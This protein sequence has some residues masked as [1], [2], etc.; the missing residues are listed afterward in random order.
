MFSFPSFGFKLFV[1]SVLLVSNL[2][3]FSVSSFSESGTEIFS[4]IEFRID[5]FQAVVCGTVFS[6]IPAGLP[7]PGALSLGYSFALFI[8]AEEAQYNLARN[9]RLKKLRDW[10]VG[11]EKNWNRGILLCDS[12]SV[13]KMITRS[14]TSTNQS[15]SAMN[16]PG[17]AAQSGSE[18]NRSGSLKTD[19]FFKTCLL[20]DISEPIRNLR[21][22]ARLFISGILCKEAWSFAF[23]PLFFFLLHKARVVIKARVLLY[24]NSTLFTFSL[25]KHL[26]M[27]NGRTSL[28]VHTEICSGVQESRLTDFTRDMCTPRLRWMPAQRIQRK[29]PRFHDAQRGP[30]KK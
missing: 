4:W 24:I 28:H 23:R 8:F 7:G 26:D 3:V 5:V 29:T 19:Q 9:V 12:G 1:V 10:C 16:R 30:E 2:L 25:F 20:F 18:M 22:H 6:T 11:N 17:S 27:K 14:E 15:G 13:L 21:T